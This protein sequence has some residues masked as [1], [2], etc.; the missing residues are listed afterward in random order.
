MRGTLGVV[1]RTL[2]SFYDDQ[3]TH[4]AAALT[5]YGLMSLFPTVLL[6]LSLLGLLGQYPE[7]YD[8]IMGYAREV[9]PASVVTPLDSS[10]R[11]ALQSK[12]T[13]TTAVAISVLVA[14]YGTTG[15]LEAARRALNVVFEIEN[16]RSFV[17]RKLIDVASTVVLLV[18][19]LVSGILV[20]VG[21]S[22]ADDLLGFIGLAPEAADIWDIARWPA[23]LLAAMLGFS[24]VY[25][26][27]PDVQHRSW[28]WM[29]PGAVT[30]VLLWLLASWGFSTYISKVADVGAIY[31][32]FAGAIVL[33]FWIWLTN[34]TLLFGA[35]LNAE[36][37][38]HKEMREGAPPHSTLN[39]PARQ[40]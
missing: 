35:E 36:I 30:G 39:R 32:A 40:G 11:S 1:K 2:V 8:A 37:E 9:A 29:T 15:V 16:G 38:R 17:R 13:A 7:T 18:L 5:Y 12:G 21:G 23:A 20:F 4:H 27:T 28:R 19:V 14:L 3:M 26:I 25:Y 34:V 24:F 31:G 22:F 10:L 6:G 33:V